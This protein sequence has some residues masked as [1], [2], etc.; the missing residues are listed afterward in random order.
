MNTT[1]KKFLSAVMAAAIVFSQA[2]APVAAATVRG[3]SSASQSDTV[4]SSRKDFG[5]SSY[6]S[7]KDKYGCAYPYSYYR[8]AVKSK[9]MKKLY[10]KIYNAL[11]DRKSSITFDRGEAGNW[12]YILSDLGKECPE[13]YYYTGYSRETIKDGNGRLLKEVVTLEYLPEKTLASHDKIFAEVLADFDA[14]LDKKDVTTTKQFLNAAL[15][16]IGSRVE[17]DYE[18]MANHKNHP[19][20]D[21]IVGAFIDGKV[22]CEGYVRAFNYLCRAYGIACC[23]KAAESESSSHALSTV[24]Y[25]NTWYN[26]D[27]TAY[28]KSY[29]QM[30]TDAEVKDYGYEVKLNTTMWISPA[31]TGKPVKPATPKPKSEDTTPKLESDT[32]EDIFTNYQYSDYSIFTF[33]V[34]NHIGYAREDG[35]TYYVIKPPKDKIDTTIDNLKKMKKDGLIT[36]KALYKGKDFV[37]VEL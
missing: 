28:K 15:A 16:F 34:K 27:P 18:G 29:K 33:I 19:D 21:N 31:A 8:Y 26:Y 7:K 35:Y 9:A 12:S 30:T 22:V 14:Y 6:W 10:V 2:S 25:K 17:Y 1:T 5:N 37:K 32:D 23:P 24:V 4:K 13:L 20:C 3:T 11:H 36:Y